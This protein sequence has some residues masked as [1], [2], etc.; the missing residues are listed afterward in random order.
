LQILG[1]SGGRFYLYAITNP[2]DAVGLFANRNHQAIFLASVLPLITYVALRADAKDRKRPIVL[3]G[4]VAGMVFIIPSILTTGS[5]NGVLLSIASSAIT[6]VLWSSHQTMVNRRREAEPRRRLIALG[7]GATIVGGSLA[8]AYIV[9]RSTAF[10]RLLSEQVG[11]E[12][13]VQLLPY[14]TRLLGAYFPVGSGFG[15][16]ELAY[17][18][19]EPL[20]LLE[21]RYL[22]QAH[23]DLLQFIIEGGL[24][25][26]LLLAAF[27]CWFLARGWQHAREFFVEGG[28][29]KAEVEIGIFA[30]ASLAIMLAGSLGDYPFRVPSM[31]LYAA[32]LCMLIGPPAVARKRGQRA[33]A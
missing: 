4:C 17:K 22:N 30:W 28:A 27:L 5:R 26:A 12:L 15:T 9:Y 31:M 24:P 23:N 21:P 32:L 33:F 6:A 13:R 19:I 2:D 16:F 10:E 3:A 14:L 29:A 7:I 20:S 1:P 8:M 25:A 18:S 11:G